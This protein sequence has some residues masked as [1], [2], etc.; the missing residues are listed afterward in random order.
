MAAALSRSIRR[1]LSLRGPEAALFLALAVFWTWPVAL[2]PAASALGHPSG[3]GLKH[4]WTLAWARRELGLG[5]LPF[6]TDW[7]NWPVGMD[8]FP[9][10]PLNALV[11]ALLPAMSLVALSN[12]LVLLNLW[13]TGLAGAWMGRELSGRAEGGLVAGLLLEGSAVMVSFVHLGVGELLHLWWL[14]LGLGWLVR[15]RRSGR[16]GPFVALGLCL[17]GATLSGFYLGFFLAVA[18]AIWALMTLS[19]RGLGPLLAR[20]ALAAG[21]GLLILGPV[22]RVFSASWTQGSVAD[23]GF[24]SW[25][26]GDHD[27]AVTD[28]VSARLEPLQLLWP[29]RALEGAQVGAYGGGRYLGF[30]ALILA[31]LGL[32]R[33]PREA[34]PWVAVALGGLTLALGSELSWGGQELVFGGGPLPLPLLYVNRAL[35]YLAEPLNFPVRALAITTVALAALAALGARGRASALVLVALVEIATLSEL[36][37][38]LARFSPQ[39]ASALEGVRDHRG[40]AIA[41]LALIWRSDAENRWSAISAQLVHQHPIQAVPIERIEYFARDGAR[42][43]AALGLVQDLEPLYNRAPGGLP[44]PLEAYRGDL[45][46]LRDAGFGELLVNYRGGRERMPDGL[47]DA[48]TALCGPPV[49]KGAATALWAVPE[50]V[51]TPDELAAWKAAHEAA[52]AALKASEHGP[53]PSW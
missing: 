5:H 17:A 30:A 2:H 50:V 1:A 6:H 39:D 4:L 35:G 52:I 37:W 18:T 36:P 46:L 10:E 28:P 45:A 11:G 40:H 47:V 20:Y 26:F 8:L 43:V 9:I 31:G 24:F 34:L 3:D 12:G 27:Q 15:A 22:L 7:V 48:L 13:A 21:L 29:A 14:P 51:Y 42:F 38:P 33:R 19:A 49:A 16:T 32:S 41:D 25:V 53:G 44:R 23:V